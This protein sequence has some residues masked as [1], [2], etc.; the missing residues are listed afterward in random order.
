[1]YFCNNKITNLSMST[2]VQTSPQRTKALQKF[3]KGLPD[4]RIC[5]MS[6]IKTEMII[7]NQK[8]T[9]IAQKAKGTT[10]MTWR[11]SSN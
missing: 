5:S 2:T 3:S 1:M 10:G 7:E 6:T 8:V 9:F 4:A 11:I